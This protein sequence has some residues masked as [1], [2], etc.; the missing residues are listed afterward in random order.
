MSDMSRPMTITEKILAQSAD[1][2]EV[3][4]GQMITARIGLVYTMDLWA[5]DVFDHLKETGVKSVFDSQK[6]VIIF[7]HCMPPT[8]VKSANLHNKIRK[9]AKEFDVP[10]YDVGHQG[11]MHQLVAEEGYLVPAII[12]VG[13]DS[14]APTGGGMGAVVVGM[15]ATDAAV[16]MATGELWLRVPSSVRVEVHGEMP[17][18]T[19]SRDI[20]TSLMGQKGWDGT[21]AV[22]AYQAVELTG[23]TVKKM[24]MDSRFSL[25]NMASDMGIKNAIVAP[26]EVTLS[27]LKGRARGTPQL[28]QSDEDATYA[29]R[30]TLDVS[31]MEPQVACPHSPDNVKPLAHVLGAKIHVA[32]IASC[33]NGRLE[34][35]QIAARIL[36]GRKVHPNVRMIVSPASQRIYSQA[37]EDGTFSVFLKAGVLISHSTCG[38][39]LGV[40]GVV[41]GDGDVCIGTLPRNMKGRLG[42]PKAEIY[43]ANPAVVAASAIK[44]EIADPREFL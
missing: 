40:Q 31:E 44:G 20:M 8:D 5:K 16:A 17:K 10:I 14:H 38:P 24:S 22:W 9:V 34:D 2:P 19:M 27:Y 12:A 36:K 21:K 7:D 35:L 41:L 23:E 11:V 4:P 33:S 6:V 28:F 39:C 29:D 42:S 18:G 1:L 32:T 26:D 15:G 25:C 43:L 3:T 37:M 13:T 30:I